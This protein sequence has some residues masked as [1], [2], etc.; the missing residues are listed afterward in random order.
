MNKIVSFFTENVLWKIIA[1]VMAV[2]LWI[3]AINIEDPIAVKIYYSVPVKIENLNVLEDFGIVLLNQE[4][5]ERSTVTVRVQANRKLLEGQLSSS[6]IAAY[7]DMSPIS[8]SYLDRLGEALSAPVGVSLPDFATSA[9]SATATPA[10]IK[11]VLD[12]LETREFPVTVVKTSDAADGY[13][14]MDPVATPAAVKVKGAKTILDSIQNVRVEV[15]LDSASA[16][17]TVYSSLAVYSEDGEDITHKVSVDTNEVEVFV[18]INR[19]AQIP[20]ITPSINGFTADGYT[21]TKVEKDV[22]YIDVVGK[23]E[24]LASINSI[25]LDPIDVTGANETMIVTRDVRDFLRTTNL[26]VRNGKPHEVNITITIEKEEIKEFIIPVSNI[27]INGEHLSAEYGESVTVRVRGVE[28]IVSELSSDSI[29]GSV[30]ISELAAGEHNVPVSFALPDGIRIVGDEP[31]LKV[32]ITD[33]EEEPTDKPIEGE[34]PEAGE[35]NTKPPE[36]SPT[37]TPTPTPTP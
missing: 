37:A 26:S 3:L 23:E 32:I 22:D 15:D 17:Y 33:V 11:I 14:S 9:H 35:T 10:D 36:E 29:K 24:E 27:E 28:R 6:N 25:K 34:E 31:V 7:V 13:V 19:H 12:K 2:I 16:D 20:V 30:N 18:P 21:I 1:L 4:E 8:F 5:V